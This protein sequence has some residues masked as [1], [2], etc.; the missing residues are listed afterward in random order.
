MHYTRLAALA[1]A[2]LFVSA[3]PSAAQQGGGWGALA[4]SENGT[5]YSYSRNYTDRDGAHQGAL[6]EC[7]KYAND[8]KI[9]ATFENKCV[10]L[11]GASD[12]AYG[13][14]IGGSDPAARSAG[15]MRQCQQ[16]GGQDCRMVVTFC[17]GVS[18]GGDPPP[19]SPG[20]A[21]PTPPSASPPSPGQPSPGPKE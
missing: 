21:S 13:W 7:A 10:A 20:P 3:A 2:F 15:A 1:G 6:A 11:A 9:Y 18:E 17:S 16:Q 8:C 5:A 19:S 14:A 4:F 12:G